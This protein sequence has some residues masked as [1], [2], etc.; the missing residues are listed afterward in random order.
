[1]LDYLVRGNQH[2]TTQQESMRTTMESTGNTEVRIVR[3]ESLCGGLI[4]QINELNDLVQQVREAQQLQQ[5]QLTTIVERTPKLPKRSPPQDAPAQ[6]STPPAS[7]TQTMPPTP[8]A[9]PVS[10]EPPPS[11]HPAFRP[12]SAAGA[13]SWS[14]GHHG[15]GCLEPASESVLDAGPA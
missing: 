10:L 6:T 3:V 5:E 14:T 1:M 9:A 4:D 7:S 15:G 8:A 2:D 11:D 13:R 12:P